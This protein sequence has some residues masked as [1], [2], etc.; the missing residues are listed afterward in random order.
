MLGKV[1]LTFGF[2]NDQELVEL[3]NSKLN[4]QVAFESRILFTMM[5]SMGINRRFFLEKELMDAE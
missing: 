2:D 4:S 5:D 1:K 3:Y